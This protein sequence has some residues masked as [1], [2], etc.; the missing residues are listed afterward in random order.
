M[1][2]A[3]NVAMFLL[4]A[5]AV[6]GC[7]VKNDGDS[8]GGMGG[9]GGLPTAGAG[10]MTQTPAGAGGVSG[11]A[12][13]AGDGAGSG[14]PTAG[15]GS[16]IGGS[17]GAGS[18]SGDDAGDEAPDAGDLA[19]AGPIVDL[20]LTGTF[21]DVTDLSAD[22]P[23][24]AVTVSNTGPGGAYTLFHP[25]ELAP[26]GVPNPIVAW[27]NGGF[28][29]PADYDYLLLH[30]ASHG[31][32]VIAANNTVVTGP[33]VRD[34]IDW[35]VAQNEDASSELYEK[36]DI[37]NVAGVGYSNG[38][39]AVSD[40]ADDPRFVTI[41][42]ISGASTSEASRTANVPKLHTPVAY[43]CTADDASRGNCEGDYAVV[44]VPAFFGVLNG[45]VH[46]SVT[47][48]LG[49]GDA[50]IMERLAGATTGWL[51]WQQ[52]SDKSRESM[53]LGSDCALCQD[54]NWTVEPQKGW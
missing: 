49:L 13:L 2:S 33:E 32:A 7:T 45:S 16:G 22:G 18:G 43:L 5:L 53:F 30:L 39:L 4:A 46:T 51:R 37:D 27:G 19:D 40:V 21:P 50:M 48:L 54:A 1:R 24:T 10:G 3:F 8:T 29:T 34:G 17:G 31:F 14:S 38:G 20:P 36:L 6:I 23:F 41:V 28:T 11:M 42:I 12:P 47:E 15:A 25:E 26:D 35:M 9:A 52:M 44:E